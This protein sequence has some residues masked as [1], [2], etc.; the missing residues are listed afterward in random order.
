[1]TAETFHLKER[2]ALREGYFADVVVFD[3]AT[4]ADRATFEKPNVLATG[5]KY[6]LVNGTLA[7]EDGGYTNA[8]A[9]RALRRQA[10]GG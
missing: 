4:I 2:G 8:R 10:A 6:V 7:V 1:M 5:V 3:P 9:G